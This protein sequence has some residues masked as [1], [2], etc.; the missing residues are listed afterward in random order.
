MIG[1]KKTAVVTAAQSGWDIPHG[2]TR[3]PQ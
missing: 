1:L 2:G 3:P